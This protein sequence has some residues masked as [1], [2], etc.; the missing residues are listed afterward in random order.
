M[1][2]FAHRVLSYF[3]HVSSQP[4]HVAEARQVEEQRQQRCM[5]SS[6]LFKQF[7]ISPSNYTSH[8][9]MSLLQIA[10][11]QIRLGSL[12]ES[13]FHSEDA[14]RSEEGVHER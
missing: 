5:T 14:Y 9:E 6:A 8:R 12:D 11:F 4:P 10:T 7:F 13:A 2:G 3:R 1:G